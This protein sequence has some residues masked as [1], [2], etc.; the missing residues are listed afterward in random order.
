MHHA[1]PARRILPALLATTLLAGG[2]LL[3][4]TAAAPAAEAAVSGTC[5]PEQLRRQAH[6]ERSRAAQLKRLGAREEARRAAA[7][8]DA[9]DRRARQCERADEIVSPPFGR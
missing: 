7:R 5:H 1:T 6:A 3:G 4:Q 2:L 9:L 8:A